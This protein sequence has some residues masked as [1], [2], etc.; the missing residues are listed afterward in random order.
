MTNTDSTHSN[1]ST[2]P[3]VTLDL[4]VHH[5]ELPHTK[6]SVC[7]D[8]IVKKICSTFSWVWLA[9]VIVIVV[10]VILRYFF[11]QG[12]VELVELQWHL[13]SSGFLIGFSYCRF[14]TIMSES[15]SSMT[16]SVLRL[17]FGSNCSAV[18]FFSSRL[19]FSLF[20][21]ACPMSAIHG[22]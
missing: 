6:A 9:L 18:C 3:H 21:M 1:S 16:G 15:I 4:I 17:R 22:G 19:F 13:Y 20:I 2:G 14:T 7:L 8:E 10:N 12:H 5:T 11:G